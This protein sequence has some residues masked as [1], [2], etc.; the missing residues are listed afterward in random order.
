MDED[1]AKY[2]SSSEEEASFPDTDEECKPLRFKSHLEST[3]LSARSESLIDVFSFVLGAL[4]T[5]PFMVLICSAEDMLSGSKKATGLVYIAASAPSCVVKVIF[6]CFQGLRR[7]S[8]V[9]KTLLMYMLVV[10]GLLCVAMSQ[11]SYDLR[12]VGVCFASAGMAIGEIYM[13]SLTTQ[14]FHKT[15][16]VSYMAGAGAGGILSTLPYVWMTSWSVVNPRAALLVPI[17]WPTLYLLVFAVLHLECLTNKSD[18]FSGVVIN[19]AKPTPPPRNLC[20]NQFM[21]VWKALDILSLMFLSNFSLFLSLGAILTTLVFSNEGDLGPREDYQHYVL[22][23]II[24]QFFGRTLTSQEARTL[25]VSANSFLEHL[26]LITKTIEEF[27]P[28][29]QKPNHPC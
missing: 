6:L 1:P 9:T 28:P 16:L 19:Q 15:A 5:A 26:I 11:T 10:V 3:Q 21:G 4:M 12:Y 22:S 29:V 2:S 27:G 25:R 8:L 24:G 23:S 14:K 18:W 13:L 17:V 20:M 7:T